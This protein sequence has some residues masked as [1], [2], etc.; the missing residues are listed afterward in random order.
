M[1]TL[2]IMLRNAVF[3]GVFKFGAGYLA[4]LESSLPFENKL[5]GAA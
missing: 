1:A 2:G 5:L 3:H 4:Y